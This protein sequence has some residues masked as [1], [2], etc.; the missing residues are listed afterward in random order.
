MSGSESL[1]TRSPRRTDSLPSVSD[2]L[3]SIRLRDAIE[4]HMVGS[5]GLYRVMNEAKNRTWNAYQ[6]KQ[7]AVRP[8]SDAP[9]VL[10]DEKKGD[11]SE[12]TTVSSMKR[13]RAASTAAGSDAAASKSPNKKRAGGGDDADGA[14][15]EADADADVEDDGDDK[16]L[17]K[18]R[19]T[20][21]RRAKAEL[22]PEPAAAAADAAP[23][24]KKR[25]GGSSLRIEPTDEE[26]ADFTASL[27]DLPHGMNKSDYTIERMRDFE[28]RY[29]RTLTFGEPPMY[30]ADMAGS[31]FKDETRA[32]NVAHL[33]DLLPKLAPTNCEIPGVVSPY[34]YF[35]MW[36]ATFAWHVEDADL[37]SINY[38]HF[39]APKFWYSVPQEQAERFERVMEGASLSRS[40]EPF[41]P[42]RQAATCS[43]SKLK[44]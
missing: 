29:W 24:K 38:I 7:R 1:T 8:Q 4:Q 13:R 31:L 14:D 44:E 26:W 33:G 40:I 35:G 28:R 41:S 34:L 5:Q 10:A 23:A 17:P 36:R 19:R 2:P 21:A 25:A 39:G 6:W 3:R 22:A 12:R 27:Y 15:E 30:G 18:G 20:P 11:R 32:W 37:Y 43:S 16:A 42:P 9:D